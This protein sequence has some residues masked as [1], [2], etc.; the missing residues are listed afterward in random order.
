M[1]VLTNEYNGG[2]TIDTNGEFQGFREAGFAFLRGLKKNNNRDWFLPRKEILEKELQKP[3]MALL[4]TVEAEMKKNKVP[5]ATK[6]KG[7]LTR[8]YR[9]IRFSTDKTPYH[10]HVGGTL[11]RNGKKDSHGAIY[12]HVSPESVF[13]GAGFWQP[14]RPVLTNWRLRMQ[15]EPKGFLDMARK[16]KNKKLEISSE[17]RLQRMPRG[18]ETAEGTAIAAYLKLQSFTVA[19]TISKD[20]AG[21]TK[22]ANIVTEFVLNALPLLEYG[23]SVPAAK[24][25]VFLD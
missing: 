14:E 7:I 11:H 16:L 20:E 12:V 4:L 6:P 18:F 19:R 25:Q 17:H 22:M 13:A 9:D 3:L 21:T 2:M 10:T 5:L 15:A 24:P 1:L 8:I 23:W